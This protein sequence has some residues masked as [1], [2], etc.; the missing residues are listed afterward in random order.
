MKYAQV[1]VLAWYING[2]T[3]AT[4]GALVV[5]INVSNVS[6]LVKE[7]G[8]MLGITM[9]LVPLLI[10]VSAINN[11]TAQAMR[12]RRA[13][14]NPKRLKCALFSVMGIVVLYLTIWSTI[15]AP[16]KRAIYGE[17]LL[18]DLS[19]IQRTGNENVIV[20]RQ[21]QCDSS[22]QFWKFVV[23]AWEFGLLLS[24]TVLAVQSRDVMAELNESKY[25]TWVIYV[26]FTF[27]ITR[28]AMFVSRQSHGITPNTYSGSV[29]IVLSIDTL[30]AVAI[31]FGPKFYE[32]VYEQPVTLPP[33]D[34]RTSSLRPKS[35]PILRSSAVAQGVTRS[36]RRR[37]IAG[38]NLDPDV[39]ERGLIRRLS[40]VIA[41]CQFSLFY[42]S[43]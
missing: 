8:I 14:V 31:Y 6:C 24:A 22:S 15:D 40:I 19:N 29:S 4:I 23:F 30:C 3:A 13:Q 2:R 17:S 41:L 34:S 18:Y 33:P 27:L 16:K 11:L 28:L 1:D 26:H 36:F 10:K 9:E 32:I 7:W 37:N 38:L 35:R 25:I 39:C 20:R 12:F 21:F 43:K 5:A 42:G